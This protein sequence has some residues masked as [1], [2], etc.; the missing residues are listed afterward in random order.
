MH[1]SLAVTVLVVTFVTHK[2]VTSLL[3]PQIPTMW[4]RHPGR[5]SRRKTMLGG[6][7]ATYAK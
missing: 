3:V 2:I 4:P 5:A 7:S 1:G 6:Y